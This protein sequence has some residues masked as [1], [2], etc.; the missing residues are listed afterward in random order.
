MNHYI[1]QEPLYKPETINHEALNQPSNIKL[2]IN[3]Y[4]NLKPL[5]KP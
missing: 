2:T 1:N 5:Y 4:I 3:H